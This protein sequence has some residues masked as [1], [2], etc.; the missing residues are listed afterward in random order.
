MLF[1]EIRSPEEMHD[2]VMEVG[3]L[4]LLANDIPGFS[5]RECSPREL[6]F[7]GEPGPWEWKGP[8]IQMGG[9]VYGKFFW[10]KAG[11]VSLDYFADFLNHRR[12]SFDMEDKFLDGQVA[13][14]DKL[15]YDTLSEH[16]SLLTHELKSYANF[17]KG[18]NKG[19]DSSITRLQ[20]QTYV[21]IDD[22]EYRM[23]KFGMEYGW[24]V[25]R[26]TTPE[27]KL[28]AD[29][30]ENAYETPLELSKKRIYDHLAKLLPH[31]SERQILGLIK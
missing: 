29:W 20:M 2:L 8:V 28:G 19:F 4:P 17:R 23:D 25:A 18:G 14:K 16:G 10:N 13:Y 22:F 27:I 11:Y 6:W 5:L 31:A 26:L 24:G 7:E 21:M 9:C 12:E 3:F 30:V 1:H 15:L